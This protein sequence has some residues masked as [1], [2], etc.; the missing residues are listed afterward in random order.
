MLR[1]RATASGDIEDGGTRNNHSV[2]G[3]QVHEEAGPK[4]HKKSKSRSPVYSAVSSSE[5]NLPQWANSGSI[6]TKMLK[7]GCSIWKMK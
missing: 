5:E 2:R 7:R 4:T 6:P 3:E 1:S